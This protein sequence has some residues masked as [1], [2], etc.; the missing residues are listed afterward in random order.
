MESEHM[1]GGVKHLPNRVELGK[2]WFVKGG[3]RRPTPALKD[4]QTGRRVS[5]L[6]PS[7]SPDDRIPDQL[8]FVPP[9]Y[10][11][12][13]DMDE[14]EGPPKLKKILLPN[15]LGAWN[16]KAGRDVFN[17]ANSCPISTCE[18]TADHAAAIDADAILYKDH[19]IQPN[20]ARPKNQ[21]KF[22]LCLYIIFF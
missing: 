5:R 11:Q 17:R 14:D 6:F 9:D 7:E 3:S 12:P 22:S 1:D 8:M 18:V 10:R 20:V 16:V 21:V 15:G 2:P 13:G 19:F 4:L